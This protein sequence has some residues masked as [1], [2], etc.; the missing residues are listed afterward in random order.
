MQ[1]TFLKQL[2]NLSFQGGKL[3]IS[4]NNYYANI[5]KKTGLQLLAVA[6]LYAALLFIYF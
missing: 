3:S 6:P 5:N 4:N 1:A 2:Y